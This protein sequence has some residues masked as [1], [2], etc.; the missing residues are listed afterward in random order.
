MTSV[1]REGGAD[2]ENQE[3]EDMD[4]QELLKNVDKKINF[5]TYE[6]LKKSSMHHFKLKTRD[7]VE[8]Y[9]FEGIEAVNSLQY[10][11]TNYVSDLIAK[12]KSKS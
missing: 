5:S 9:R 10:V 11:L 7:V 8:V 3:E 1:K 4:I 6:E 12:R 2:G